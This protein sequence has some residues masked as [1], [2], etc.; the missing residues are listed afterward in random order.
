M[1][2]KVLLMGI[3]LYGNLGGPSLLITTKKVL[4]KSFDK[5]IEYKL[6]SNDEKGI[7]QKYDIDAIFP[8]APIIKLIIPIIA[9][10]LFNVKV[11]NKEIRKF[12]TQISESDMLID[13]SGI[14]F[15][16]KLGYN[17]FGY[18]LKEGIP[19]ILYGKIFRKP[20]IKY[21]ADLGPFQTRWNRI[22]SKFYLNYFTDLIFARG[23]TTVKR[24][25]QLNI[26]T[27]VY[28]APDTAFLLEPVKTR[29]AEFLINKK[30]DGPIIGFS[31]SHMAARQSNNPEK[32][33]EIM[34]D[35]AD[36]IIESTGAYLVFIPNELYPEKDSSD[37]Y[38]SQ[39]VINKM[40]NS[41]KTLLIDEDVHCTR[42]KRDH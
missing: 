35:F 40:K 34:A 13:I 1:P 23:E 26:K 39:K 37:K 28:L 9:Q 14:R 27:P 17:T 10:A 5:T 32:Y 24:L 31:T 12:V 36:Y 20:V 18:R 3:K 42:V 4:D 25:K 21:T 15:S 11:G 6:I 8:P 30:K 41:G 22:F 29:M 7:T 33:C 38:I 16:D 2:V 19:Y